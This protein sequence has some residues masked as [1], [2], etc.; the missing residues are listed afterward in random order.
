ME[1]KTLQDVIRHGALCFGSQAAFRYKEKKEVVENSE[2][3]DLWID[4]A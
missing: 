1:V 4:I 2:P 3:W